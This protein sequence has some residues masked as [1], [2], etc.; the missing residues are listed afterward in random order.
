[1]ASDKAGAVQIDPLLPFKIGLVNGRE[2]RESGLR[3]KASVAPKADAQG[4]R[5]AF[6]RVGAVRSTANDLFE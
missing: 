1:M 6:R 4:G 3:L 5:F 2:A